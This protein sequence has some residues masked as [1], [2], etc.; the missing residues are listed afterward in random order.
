VFVT[1]DKALQMQ[2]EDN[3]LNPKIIIQPI[4]D[5]DIGRTEEILRPRSIIPLQGLLG[6]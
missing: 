6:Y 4:G 2:N 1:S 5:V 3:L